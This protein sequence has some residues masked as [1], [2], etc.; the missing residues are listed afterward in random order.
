VKKQRQKGSILGKIDIDE[1]SDKSVAQQLKEALANNAG[2]VIDLFREWDADGDG[3][4]TRK[5]FHK[6]MPLLGFEVS[7]E[8]ID[9]VFDEFDVE[10]GGSISYDELKKLLKRRG[11]VPAARKEGKKPTLGDAGKAVKETNKA[12]GAMKKPAAASGSEAAKKPATKGPATT[13]K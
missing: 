8:E 13:K 9:V 12:V 5:E 10:G 3:T 11:E 1:D 7:K 4:I 6:A 2:K